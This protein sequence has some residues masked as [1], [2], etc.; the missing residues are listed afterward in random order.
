[1]AQ[2]YLPVSGITIELVIIRMSTNYDFGP[3]DIITS[4]TLDSKYLKLS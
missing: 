3:A 2:N 1:M 4:F